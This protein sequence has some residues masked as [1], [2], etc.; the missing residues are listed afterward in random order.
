VNRQ[1]R[2]S[3]RTFGTHTVDQAQEPTV[4]DLLGQ[5]RSHD[6]VVQ[7]PKAVGD[8]TL[9]E[10]HSSRPP[11]VDLQQRR[12]TPVGRPE[13]VR[14]VGELRLVV[15][16]QNETQRFLQQFVRA[17]QAMPSRN[18]A[19][20]P[21]R[22][23]WSAMQLP[24]ISDPA[25]RGRILCGIAR[26]PAA[27][28]AVVLWLI[29]IPE[30]AKQIAW[31]RTDLTDDL[32]DT[33]IS[34]GNAELAEYLGHNDRV[35]TSVRWRLAAHAE[36]KVRAAAARHTPPEN[37]TPGC[38]VPGALLEHLADDGDASVRAQ[39]AEHTSTPDHSRAVLAADPDPEVR[40]TVAQWWTQ[41]PEPVR[42][43]LLTDPDPH[44]R[45][46]AITPWHPPPPPDLHDRLLADPA[47]R[48]A[49][50]PYVTLTNDLADALSTA[51][52]EQ[53]RQALATNPSLPATTREFLTTDP[54][55]L[56][57]FRLLM[58][59]TTPE[60]TRSRLLTAFDAAPTEADRWI[61]QYFLGNAWRD[62]TSL[63]WLSDAPIPERLTYL[64]SPHY[65]F[66][67]AVAASSGL[68]QH[69]IDQLLADPDIHTRR[70]AAMIHGAPADVLEQIVREHGEVHHLPPLLV[71]RPNFPR[72][73]LARYATSDLARL[74]HLACH[75][76]DLPPELV[77]RL[78]AD[79]ETHVRRAA[80]E[81]PNLP[82]RCLPDLLTDTD[83]AIAEAA[84]ASPAMPIPW[85]HSL[86][87]N[88]GA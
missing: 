3:D 47:T 5:D 79:T 85:M 20:G 52:D 34:I 38:E 64:D 49:V 32:A 16:R 66:R 53:V 6:R 84:A 37:V 58:N 45:V 41:A 2:G 31:R 4:V 48:A 9:D 86:L 12:M 87:I 44:V 18:S 71:E 10:P 27:P 56:V 55:I 25:R 42:R 39:V 63:G 61:I 76:P 70:I 14:A 82:T 33:I 74:R 15:R 29:G 72:E 11:V 7:R 17:A 73:A 36:P 59:P 40:K 23:A 68:P 35:P 1:V 67:Q 19:S 28:P 50:A 8:V 78:A 57:R 54:D 83:L 46:A 75:D 26:N 62:Q 60:S 65:F 21:R 24:V 69:A 22:I 88:A 81:H 77:A 30:P 80:A 51:A 43:A 13:P